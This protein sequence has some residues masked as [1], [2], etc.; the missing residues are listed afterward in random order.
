MIFPWDPTFLI[1]RFTSSF[2][3]FTVSVWHSM[4]L[5]LALTPSPLTA[6]Y[7]HYWIKT[8][9]AN[10]YIRP[11]V[12]PFAGRSSR[13]RTVPLYLWLF[14][15]SLISVVLTNLRISHTWTTRHRV[16]LKTCALYYRV[17][18]IVQSSN[19]MSSLTKCRPIPNRI[20]SLRVPVSI[21]FLVRGI[22]LTVK[23]QFDA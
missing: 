8:E 9:R 4:C 1:V 6:E 10:S 17:L 5:S 11:S 15:H 18:Q 13:V 2:P 7:D 21:G 16:V 19:Y 14:T 3:L 23:C 20:T 12:L 22:R